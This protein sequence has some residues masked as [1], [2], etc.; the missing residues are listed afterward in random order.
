MKKTFRFL[1][2]IICVAPLFSASAAFQVKK[3]A[4]VA[5]KAS[6][7]SEG[8]TSLVPSVI[9]LVSGVME[10][11]AKQ[12]NLSEECIPTNQEMIF[13]D[14]MLK[15][16]A[17]TGSASY[18]EKSTINGRNPCSSQDGM[19]YKTSIQTTYAPGMTTC[20]NTFQGPGNDNMVWQWFPK[21]GKGTYCK[22][23]QQYCPGNE[24]TA[25]D[26]YDLFAL[27]DFDPSDYKPSEATMAA[28]LMNKVETCSSAKLSAKKKAL[29]GQ[30]LVN[31][32]GSVGTKTNTGTIMEQVSS[33]GSGGA[34][35][36]VGSLGT[37]AA[38]FM[39]K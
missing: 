28:K 3:A 27:I 29:W 20:Y 8:A 15:E 18:E 4:P 38:Q 35:G 30:F 39:N 36:A 11:N 34:A 10:V 37:V 26:T 32:A 5:T 1:I 7:G 25:S 19:G 9:G 22:D 33:F 17:K 24:I 14:N 31:T 23:G 6:A 13:V 2:A 16:W 12:K 21:T